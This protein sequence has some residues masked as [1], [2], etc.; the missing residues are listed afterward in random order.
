MKLSGERTQSL[1]TFIKKNKKKEQMNWALL[2][3]ACQQ[4]PGCSNLPTISYSSRK[5]I[6]CF[7]TRA[8]WA[9][10]PASCVPTQLSDQ[11]PLSSPVKVFCSLPCLVLWLPFDWQLI[12]TPGPCSLAQAFAVC[13]KW[14][15]VGAGASLVWHSCTVTSGAVCSN[16]IKTLAPKPGLCL[17][18][19]PWSA[20]ELISPRHLTLPHF[21]RACRGYITWRILP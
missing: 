15:Q 9:C 21:F 7:L 3:W 13:C 5:Y 10:T 14:L 16:G 8:Q 6:R 11:G 2:A 19:S 12:W 1:H 4:L 17:C 20:S 18:L